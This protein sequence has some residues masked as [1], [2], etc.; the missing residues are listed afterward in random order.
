MSCSDTA[1]HSGLRPASFLSYAEVPASGEAQRRLTFRERLFGFCHGL[2]KSDAPRNPFPTALIFVYLVK[3]VLYVLIFYGAVRDPS[4]SLS[5]ERNAKRWIVYNVLT[6]AIGMNATRQP[7]AAA[8]LPQFPA[9]PRSGPRLPPPSLSQ[10]PGLSSQRPDGLP[11]HLV[12]LLRA[13]L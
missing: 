7:L 2:N 12:V 6:D 11:I 8:T 5:D 13:A 10:R 1:T 9:C 4:L 3:C